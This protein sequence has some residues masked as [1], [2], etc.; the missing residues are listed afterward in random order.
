[1][2]CKYILKTGDKEITFDDKAALIKYVRANNLFDE[3]GLKTEASMKTEDLANVLRQMTFGEQVYSPN[4]LRKF[5]EKLLSEFMRMEE[6]S[7]SFYKLGSIIALTKGLG[8]S[9]DQVDKIKRNLEDLGVG[10]VLSPEELEQLPFDARYLVTGNPAYKTFDNQYHHEITSN[11]L[12]IL[13]E[14]DALSKTMFLE[15]TPSFTGVISKTLANLKSTITDD[16]VSDIKDFF[17]AFS[18]IAAYKQWLKINE[19]QTSTLRNSLIYDTDSTL[20]NIIDIVKEV[21]NLAPENTFLQFILP[22]STIVKTGKKLQLNINNKDLINTIEGK[23]RGSLEPDMIATL[24]DSFTE[25]YQN[26]KTQYHAKAL[27]DYLIVK[28]GLMFKN[29][30]FVRM[31]PTLMFND[32]SDAT[33]I[34]TEVMAAQTMDEYK[35]ILKKLDSLEIVDANGQY[36]EYFTKE[37]KESYN[38][39][40]KDKDIKAMQNKM[41][42]K[43]FGLD[44]TDLY[45]Q[46]E[47]VYATDVANQFNLELIK[48]LNEKKRILDNIKYEKAEDDKIYMHVNLFPESFSKLEKDSDERKEKFKSMIKELNAANFN[49]VN[50]DDKTNIEFKRY[51]RVR[52]KGSNYVTFELISVK[53]GKDTFAKRG[54]TAA[55][56]LVPQ[57][58]YAIYAPVETVGASNTTGYADLGK[59]P[60]PAELKTNVAKKAEKVK[61]AQ[62]EE[63]PATPPV[64]TAEPKTGEPVTPPVP[65]T[66]ASVVAT[67]LFGGFQQLDYDP[68]T[69]NPITYFT[70]E[71]IDENPC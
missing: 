43:V 56:D 42:E 60:T 63:T 71:Q 14:I 18:Q 40:V 1:M 22:V 55:G 20:P 24:M 62:I 31:L 17:S 15:R 3:V 39:I 38:K 12:R 59:R 6:Q 54:L 41:F 11:N 49:T 35:R 5:Q 25:L 46:F 47:N 69:D 70:D 28:D 48:P 36:K 65:P 16:K 51:V 4:E 27:Y 9:F 8:K 57:G 33:G 67:G 37:E 61:A 34:A 2:A 44:Y 58:T 32:M 66:E 52:G 21:S 23:T 29:K 10:V 7:E 68:S 53:R 30:S 19:K 45:A 13:N 50:E 26:P 64:V